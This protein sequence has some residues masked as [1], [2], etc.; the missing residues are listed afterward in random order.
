MHCI[1]NGVGGYTDKANFGL[2]YPFK[3][4]QG[5]ID[6]SLL[7]DISSCSRMFIVHSMAAVHAA[8]QS[9]AKQPNPDRRSRVNELSRRLFLPKVAANAQFQVPSQEIENIRPC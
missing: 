5:K 1:I 6:L 7:C 9:K 3:L 2:V 8:K 4:S